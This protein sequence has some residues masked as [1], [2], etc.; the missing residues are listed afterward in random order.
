MLS[1]HQL[2]AGPSPPQPSTVL[3]PFS[4][5]SGCFFQAVFSSR[6]L[7][8]TLPF[9]L[10]FVPGWILGTA[11]QRTRLS[12]PS[13]LSLPR[14]RVPSARAAKRLA[15]CSQAYCAMPRARDVPRHHNHHR[16]C[17]NAATVAAPQTLP[18]FLASLRAASTSPP[19]SKSRLT[20]ETL[21]HEQFLCP[22]SNFTIQASARLAH[23][24]RPSPS[25]A[26]RHHTLTFDFHN[27]EWPI[28][29]HSEPSA[30]LAEHS[31]TALRSS[32]TSSTRIHTRHAHLLRPSRTTATS[33]PSLSPGTS[34]HAQ[35]HCAQIDPIL[36]FLHRH[37]AS[38][39][40]H[41]HL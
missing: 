23:I 14:R 32:N 4:G 15:V 6:P 31:T 22:L 37:S 9:P 16:L 39:R 18:F 5:F 10:F 2:E 12:S 36:G 3:R 11:N 29:I 25:S 28:A 33:T 35:L 30:A 21:V 40:L 7:T 38:A 26:V 27:R 24:P 20:S 41:R 13:P 34:F 1:L 8:L 19:Q 17:T